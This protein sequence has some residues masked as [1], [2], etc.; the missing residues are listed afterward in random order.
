MKT[1]VHSFSLIV[2]LSVLAGCAKDAS[3]PEASPLVDYKP[4]YRRGMYT[5][6]MYCSRCHDTGNEGAPTLDDVDEWESRGILWP[7]MLQDHVRDGFLD[8][9]S[10]GKGQTELS[11]QNIADAIYFMTVKIEAGK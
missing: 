8:M 9:P 11:E 10:M 4:D 7:A 1:A 2:L 3:P 5:Y 6:S